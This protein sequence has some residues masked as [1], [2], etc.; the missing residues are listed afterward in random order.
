MKVIPQGFTS[1]L[2]FVV[3]DFAL[4]L[5]SNSFQCFGQ[6]PK[7]LTFKVEGEQVQRR[8]GVGNALAK[9]QA[10]SPCRGQGAIPIVSGLGVV[11]SQSCDIDQREQVAFGRVHYL[12]ELIQD[13]RDA[14][15]LDEPEVCKALLIDLCRHK[16]YNYIA[17]MGKIEVDG[18][19][20]HIGAH[21][22]AVQVL[23]KAW[24]DA[25]IAQRLFSLSDDGLRCFQAKPSNLTG[26]YALEDD[27]FWSPP[28]DLPSYKQL[29]NATDA[30]DRLKQKK[31][32][33]K[34]QGAALVSPPSTLPNPG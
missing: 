19:R 33:A 21:L 18:Q 13:Y 11:L 32:Q 5:V 17:Y 24:Q 22:L 6:I 30:F 23:P 1:I 10:F 12:E 28:E 26:R 20:R 15:E 8:L 16:G 25:L 7:T 3:R 2:R 27:L 29:R 4:H 31:Q 14:L 34:A 9:E